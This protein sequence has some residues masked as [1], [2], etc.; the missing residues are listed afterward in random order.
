MQSDR[1]ADLSQASPQPP[2]PRCGRRAAEEAFSSAMGD[3]NG[4]ARAA[5]DPRAL[6]AMLAV[7]IPA[8]SAVRGGSLD[9]DLEDAVLE[10]FRDSKKNTEGTTTVPP[11]ATMFSNEAEVQLGWTSFPDGSGILPAY[12]AAAAE[13]VVSPALMA[14][15]PL[16]SAIAALQAR[17]G[18]DYRPDEWTQ[19]VER[20]TGRA[21]GPSVDGYVQIPELD[22]GGNPTVMC[23]E[24]FTSFNS[25]DRR[26]L[27][28]AVKELLRTEE[29]GGMRTVLG[30][31]LRAARECTARKK[32]VLVMLV[33]RVQLHPKRTA[34]ASREEL[35]AD[36]RLV[37]AKLKLYLACEEHV[38]ELKDRAFSSTFLEP[39]KFYYRAVSD[40]IM[41]GD[42]DIHGANTYLAA[43]TSTLGIRCSRPAYLE[44]E[45]KGIIDFAAAGLV[46]APQ[47]GR[48]SSGARAAPSRGFL[49]RI[50][51]GSGSKGPSSAP[52]RPAPRYVGPPVDAL[53]AIWDTSNAGKAF[54]SVLVESDDCIFHARLG[55]PDV[56]LKVRKRLPAN[57]FLWARPGRIMTAA[58]LGTAACDDFARDN[59]YRDRLAVYLAQFCR[60]FA[61]DVLL[62]RLVNMAIGADDGSLLDAAQLV[63]DDLKARS[64]CLRE[65]EEPKQSGRAP[66]SPA[67]VTLARLQDFDDVRFWLWDLD[68]GDDH[69]GPKLDLV[70][71]QMLLAHA[72]AAKP[73]GADPLPVEFSRS[74]PSS[75]VEA[76]PRSIWACPAC[77]Y[78]NHAGSLACEMCE[79]A[80]PAQ[81]AP[82]P[83]RT[84]SGLGSDPNLATLPAR[85]VARITAA[86]DIRGGGTGREVVENLLRPESREHWSKWLHPGPADRSWIQYDLVAPTEVAAYGLCSANDS[87]GRDPAAWILLGRPVGSDG[88]VVLHSAGRDRPEEFASRFEWKWFAL[89]AAKGRRFDRLR[90]EIRQV[91]SV[92]DGIQLA[93]WHIVL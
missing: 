9:M 85:A 74:W 71:A 28:A 65:G 29:P 67:D 26:V 82:A 58:D 22:V 45:C 79:S 57:E 30:L 89:P 13:I 35:A 52:P 59:G 24:F 5:C 83:S 72:G 54:E 56:Q 23:W 21:F 80:R 81:Y 19:L 14:G 70:A 37:L 78:H 87:P 76:S 88:W 40:V 64:A 92:G 38:E 63:F 3:A 55:S 91:R 11:L 32:Q 27:V 31:M 8:P 17:V 15:S 49:E 20:V 44:D 12:R 77:T 69:G 6:A 86:G 34:S 68:D 47:P 7:G 36:E 46:A 4:D 33:R 18:P 62:P 10:S 16:S 51:G 73:Y 53:A 39:T 75:P 84:L 42:T 90:L 1:H 60:Y 93:H 61:A 2:N 48:R 50:F 25:F 41:E 66:L 43:L